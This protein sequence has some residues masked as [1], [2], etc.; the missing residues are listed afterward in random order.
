[1][2]KLVV[3]TFLINSVGQ[4]NI[5][6][7]VFRQCSSLTSGGG[8]FMDQVSSNVLLYGC[9]FERC[10]TEELGGAIYVKNANICYL[11][12]DCFYMCS[13]K[14]INSVIIYGSEFYVSIAHTNLTDEYCPYSNLECSL[15]SAHNSFCTQNNYSK[16]VTTWLCAGLY[17]SSKMSELIS[18][19]CQVCDC[20]G[21]SF[22][23]IWRTSSSTTLLMNFI[24]N[25]VTDGWIEFHTSNLDPVLIS[26]LFKKNNVTKFAKYFS[27]SGTP[28]CYNCVFDVPNSFSISINTYY[29]FLNTY[30]PLI[31]IPFMNTFQ[32]WDNS[33][34]IYTPVFSPYPTIIPYLCYIFAFE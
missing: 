11:V 7:S 34:R 27:S 3:T 33:T 22:F 26:I 21:P 19:F 25:S 9:L 20:Y 32:C 4:Y 10:H 23:G 31:S 6:N 17:C 1:M 2:L 16:A 8:I 15:Y 24:N 18:S 29:N 14:Q 12:R 13:S 28:V 30:A 5:N